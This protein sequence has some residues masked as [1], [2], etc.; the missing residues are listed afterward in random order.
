MS[1]EDGM[2]EHDD[3]EAVLAAALRPGTVDDTATRAAVAA[4]RAARDTGL[5]GPRRTR[6]R[7]DWRYPLDARSGASD[8]S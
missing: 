5:H 3:V 8:A 6:R 2:R 1:P 7:D 4:F